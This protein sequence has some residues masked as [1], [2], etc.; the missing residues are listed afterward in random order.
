MFSFEV[1]IDVYCY[2]C[3]DA[4]TDPHLAKHLATFGIE[5]AS[6]KKTEKSMT[7]LVRYPLFCI[8]RRYRADVLEGEVQQ[9]EQNMNFDFAMTG[10]DGKELEPVFGPGLTGL[11]NLG[12]SCVECR[13]DTPSQTED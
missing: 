12:N 1:S 8:S 9:V 6:Q 10:A 3:D 7:E 11:K 4:R 5:V 13:F 2:A